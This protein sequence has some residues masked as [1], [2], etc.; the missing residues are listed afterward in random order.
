[1]NWLS[2]NKKSL[3]FVAFAIWVILIILRSGVLSLLSIETLERFAELP[4]WI[5]VLGL[6]MI[7][8]IMGL[9]MVVPKSLLYITAGL[10]FPTW[11]GVLITYT[12]LA[13][14]ASIG[15]T[16]GRKMG[17]EKVRK[18]LDKQKKFS[19]FLNSENNEN[20]LSVCFISRVFPMPFVFTSL[21]FGALRLPFIKFI[22]AS[23][24]GA[25]P[26]MVPIVLAGS[27]IANPLSAEFLIPFGISFAIMVIIVVA[28]KAKL[29]TKDRLIVL[30]LIVQIYLFAG[31]FNRIFTTLPVVAILLYTVGVWMVTHIVKQDKPRIYKIRWSIT[32]LSLPIIGGLFYLLFGDRHSENETSS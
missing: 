11:I 12:G 24:L 22:L 7:Y 17:E 9:T 27:A 5:A 2:K 8:V 29:V 10:V 31:L 30:S 20:L 14:A 4:T 15:Y 23:L 19:D 16:T 32:V 18:M 6:L 28:Y 13:I 21:F 26:L 25:T 1:M 3:L